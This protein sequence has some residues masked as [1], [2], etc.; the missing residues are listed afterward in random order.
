VLGTGAAALLL[1]VVAA[2]VLQNILFK[3]NALD[4]FIYFAVTGLLTAVAAAACFVPARRATRVNPM[5]ALR[6][7]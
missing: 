7:E 2:A 5:E 6:A 4:P 3:V 1:G